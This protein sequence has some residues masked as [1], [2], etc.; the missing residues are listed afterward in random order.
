M[1][2]LKVFVFVLC[3]LPVVQLAYLLFYTPL[4]LGANPAEYIIRALGDWSIYFILGGLAITPLRHITGVNA[5]IKFRRMVGL[6]AFFYVCLHLLAYLGFDRLFIFGEIVEDV[7]K[8]PFIAVG[9]IAFILLIPLAI[10]STRGFVLRMGGKNWARLH[11]L[12]Y[13][14]AVLGVVHYWWLVK[15]D[16]TWP[17]IYAALLAALFLLRVAPVKSFFKKYSPFL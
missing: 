5:L 16:L 7:I 8:R 14:I 4:N 1:S 6:F 12:I 10:T 2:R 11:K 9:F 13:L 3:L 17:M 15:K